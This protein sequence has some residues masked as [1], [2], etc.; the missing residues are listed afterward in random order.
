MR[1]Q[2]ARVPALDP[3]GAADQALVL[4]PAIRSDDVILL[5]NEALE[6]ELGCGLRDPRI[7]RVA[8]LVEEPRRLDQ[9]LRWEAP[10]VH[11]RAADRPLLR[12]HGALAE[13]LRLQRRR[14]SRGARAED[15]EVEEL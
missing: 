4:L 13:L 8:G 7:S 3:D 11:A 5:S 2:E 6:V 15:H 1:V 9:V 14:E 12:H 10:A